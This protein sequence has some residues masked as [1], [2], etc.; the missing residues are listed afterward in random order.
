MKMMS[1]QVCYAEAGEVTYDP[2]QVVYGKLVDLWY[3]RHDSTTP[4]R[5]GNDVHTQYTSGRGI[6]RRRAEAGRALCCGSPSCL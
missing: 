3:S 1:V 6:P 5:A 2:Q 4:S